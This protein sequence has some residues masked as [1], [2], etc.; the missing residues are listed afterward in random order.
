MLELASLYGQGPIML[1]N[2]AK[3]QEISERYLGQI[4]IPLRTAGLVRAERGARGGYML[5][6]KPE[7]VT[8]KQIVKAVEGELSLVDCVKAPKLC[9]RSKNCVARTVWTEAAR[10][11]EEYMDSLTL[12]DLMKMDTAIKKKKGKDCK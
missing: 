11:V 9:D 8:V 3:Q 10:R 1:K 2:I 6:K 4:V 5:A 7:S 12:T